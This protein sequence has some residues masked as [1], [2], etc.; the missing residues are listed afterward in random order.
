VTG[1]HESPLRRAGVY[2]AALAVL[3]WVA[4]PLLWLLKSSVTP[5]SELTASPSA[6]LPK[7]PTLGYF[8][9]LFTDVPGIDAGTGQQSLIVP[10]LGKSLI[11][12]T[13]VMALN[14]LLAAPAAYVLA[15]F[16][17][18]GRGAILNGMLASRMVPS[19]VLLVPFYLLFRY[20]GLVDTVFAVVVAH[21]A[22]TLPFSVWI[23]RGHFDGVPREVEKAARVDGASRLRSF[24]HVALPLAAPGLVVAGL[25]A[26]M[27][28][29]N[30]FPLALVLT[31]SPSAMTVQPALAGL[32]SYQGVSYG[33]LFAG[34][35]L[36]AL[37]PALIA[38]V[39][40]RHLAEGLLEGSVK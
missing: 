22:I 2:L 35:V 40:Q 16:R 39:L 24:R 17:F 33:F 31:E 12:A 20:A 21:V 8:R 13:C 15:R 23:L 5:V 18:R 25:F 27:Q 1:L 37:P 30:E 34:A 19:L 29:W 7:H 3:V 10:A 4:F 9:G 6:V 14:V 28:S 36:A 26:F 11:T 32:V 38:L